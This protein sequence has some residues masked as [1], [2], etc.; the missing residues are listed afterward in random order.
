MKV[1]IDERF[2]IESD[3]YNFIL[4]EVK[5][6]KGGKGQERTVIHGYYGSVADAL[7]KVVKLKIKESTAT[8]IQELV[9]DVRRI[10]EYI[11]SVVTV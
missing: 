9:T 1:K 11:R 10:E 4:K 6:A 7:N 3:P 5:R 2:S 8:T